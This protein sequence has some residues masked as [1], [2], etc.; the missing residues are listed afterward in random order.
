MCVVL[1]VYGS[2]TLN[3][4]EESTPIFW[5]WVVCIFVAFIC[6]RVCLCI[7]VFDSEYLPTFNSGLDVYM[8][9]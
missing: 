5:A 3:I 2:L 6:V 7:W 4:S 1:C 9:L 8:G